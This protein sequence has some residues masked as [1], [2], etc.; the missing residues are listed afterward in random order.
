MK[1]WLFLTCELVKQLTRILTVCP[2]L[3]LMA[4]QFV[5]TRVSFFCTNFSNLFGI[6]SIQDKL[7]ITFMSDMCNTCKRH[8]EQEREGERDLISFGL[9]F[10]LPLS[11]NAGSCVHNLQ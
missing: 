1:H 10:S 5:Q 2:I 6:A 7:L 4:R 8:T 3:C 11:V 9:M